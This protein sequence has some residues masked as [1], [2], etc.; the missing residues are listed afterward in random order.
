MHLI[1][2]PS[3]WVN[4]Y[5]AILILKMERKKQHFWYP[6]TNTHSKISIKKKKK[7]KPPYLMAERVTA[8]SA[9]ER[10]A[11]VCNKS[12]FATKV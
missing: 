4:F 3:K 10:A 8:G 7:K 1:K 6:K 12:G 5:V 2:I 9:A 11:A